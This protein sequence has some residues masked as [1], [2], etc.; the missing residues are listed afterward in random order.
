MSQ[1]PDGLWDTAVVPQ[2]TATSYEDDVAEVLVYL[3][4]DDG[5]EVTLQDTT[6]VL[7]RIAM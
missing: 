6:P 1:C 5:A 3:D 2:L 4:V 7:Q